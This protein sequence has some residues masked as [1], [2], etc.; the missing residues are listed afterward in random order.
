M[1]NALFRFAWM[2]WIACT[3]ACNGS[4]SAEELVQGL[5]I[6]G[7]SPRVPAK[8]LQKV[9]PEIKSDIET[10][11]GWK[12]LSQPQLLLIADREG[13]EKMTGSPFIS[14]FAVPSQHLIVMLLSSESSRQYILNETFK[15][16]LCHLLL[17]DHIS[18]VLLPRWLDEGICQ[19]V[20]GSLGEIAMGR[21][22]AAWGMDIARHPI[23]LEQLTE[24]FPQEKGTLLLAYEE[25]R[26]FVEYLT[27]HYGKHSLLAILQHLKQGDDIDRAVLATLSKSLKSLHQEWLEESRNWNVWFIWAS[28]HLYEILFFMGALLT[29]LAFVRLAIRKRDYFAE[30]EDEE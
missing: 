16:E 10:V 6:V 2:A 14:A 9:Y 15:H 26:R 11:L 1:K 21:G 19:W 12:L 4:V 20:S 18:E 13:F 23:P 24:R 5:A 3:L 30:H 7:E 8:Q 28:Q 29:V 25:S 22:V 17:H 27:A